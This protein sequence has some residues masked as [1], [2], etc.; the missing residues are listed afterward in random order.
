[1]ATEG[2]GI[3]NNH[4]KITSPLLY[5]VLSEVIVKVLFMSTSCLRLVKVKIMADEVFSIFNVSLLR[6]NHPLTGQP[7]MN[8]KFII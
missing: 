4:S 8:R 1:M 3:V 5:A 7:L 2:Q 6:S